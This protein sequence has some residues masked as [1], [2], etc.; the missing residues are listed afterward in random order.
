[1]LRLN[2]WRVGKQSQ[3]GIFLS[4]DSSFLKALNGIN[5]RFLQWPIIPTQFL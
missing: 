2:K 1:M 3:I 5:H 4:Q